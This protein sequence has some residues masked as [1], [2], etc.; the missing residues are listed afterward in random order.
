[1]YP[2]IGL[3]R[4]E[5]QDKLFRVRMPEQLKVFTYNSLILEMSDAIAR[6]SQRKPRLEDIDTKPIIVQQVSY[7][8]NKPVHCK[9]HMNIWQKELQVIKKIY[10]NYVIN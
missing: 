2:R 9:I 10:F 8:D 7:E 5:L 6:E 4:D 1:M 3:E